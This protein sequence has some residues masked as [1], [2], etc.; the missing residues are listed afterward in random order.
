[1]EGW[2]H[3]V[4][5][6]LLVLVIT[7]CAVE[8]GTVYVKDGQ[9]YG[10]VSSKTWRDRWWN[11]YERGG[12]YAAGEF[13]EDAISDFRAAITQRQDDQRR[14]RTYGL[15]F[16]DY[17]PH[18]ELGIVY[19]RLERHPDAIRELETSLE[20]ADNAKAKFYLNKARKSLL[21]QRGGDTAAPR[22][23]LATPANELLTN[24]FTVDVAGHAED[25]TYVSSININGRAQ[26]VELAEPR[27]LFRQAIALHDGANTVDIVAA[28]LLGHSAH[29][30][31]TVHLDRQ[32]P[33]LGLDR[34]EMVGS[35]PL[36]RV[37]VDGFLEDR[38][39]IRRFVLVG[40]PVP[41]QPG[42]AWEFRQEIQLPVGMT[43]LPFEVED[44]AGNITRG[45]ILLTPGAA[46]PIREGG[47]QA[48]PRWTAVHPDTVVIDLPASY[49]VA[50]QPTP[51]PD[52]QAP[53]IK[54]QGLVEQQTVYD[55]TIYIEGQVTDAS[56]ITAFAINGESLW[57]RPTRQVFFGQKFALQEGDNTFLLEARDEAGNT[58]QHN[59]VV[60]R[61]IHPV[62]RVGARLR[63]SLLPFAKQGSASVLSESVYDNL[64]NVVVNQGRFDMVERQQLDTI[65]QELKLSQ[66][67]LV[68]P[69]TAA[70]TG[71]IMAAEGML[72]GT[73]TETPQALEV[74]VRFVDVES[75]VVLAAVDVYGEDLTL[76]GM[77]RLMDGMAWKLQRHF[78]LVEGLVLDK[79]G[80]VLLTDLSEKQG[81]KRNMKL[82]VYRDG[83]ALQHP[84]SGKIFQKPDTILGEA[85]IIAVSPD[86]S[87][88]TLLPSKQTVHVQEADKVI[89]K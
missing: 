46:G 85:R 29:E 26:F 44:A 27:M 65:L 39:G 12:S 45:E 76:P 77:R 64:F 53:V 87:K 61:D 74:F 60:R 9:Q 59:I 34:L 17:F 84:R 68:D 25:D 47:L 72:L 52:Q 70:K 50:A 54:L 18:R 23:L 73:V 20:S 48:L 2:R 15:H 30:R 63:V 38:S 89:T 8:H 86:L 35:P 56:L 83:E 43:S 11:Y 42:T 24:R 33:L 19:Y 81:V 67:S 82:I 6:L 13:W 4:L 37:H 40:R 79:E 55:D 3:G 21:Q 58:V 66:T 28:D 51:A 57:R 1:M 88:A 14:A 80:E 49:T 5:A 71:K 78:P 7:G 31:L 10:V 32:G 36:Q 22:I 69:A 62:K 41:L 16:I 75:S